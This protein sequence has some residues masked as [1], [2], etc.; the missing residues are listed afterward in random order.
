MRMEYVRKS[1][2]TEMAHSTND[3]RKNSNNETDGER[4]RD[5]GNKVS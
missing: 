5:G 2:R 1:G 3:H 4:E